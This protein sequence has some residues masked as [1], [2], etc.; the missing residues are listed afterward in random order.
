LSNTFWR[1]LEQTLEGFSPVGFEEM[2]KK[3]QPKKPLSEANEILTKA[4]G[5]E[6]RE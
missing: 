1:K 3:K 2:T 6:N 5:M 4:A